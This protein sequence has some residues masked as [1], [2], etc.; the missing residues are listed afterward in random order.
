MST[1]KQL[2]FMSGEVSPEFQFNSQEVSYATGLKKLLNGFVRKEGGVSNRPGFMQM[3]DNPLDNASDVKVNGATGD[4]YDFPVKAQGLGPN[5]TSYTFWNQIDK[6][7]DI[8]EIGKFDPLNPDKVQYR[9]NFS[10][11][12]DIAPLDIAISNGLGPPSH[13]AEVIFAPIESLRIV[14]VEDSI[15]LFPYVWYKVTA[16]FNVNY[17]INISFNLKTKTWR[18]FGIQVEERALTATL[19]GSSN[20]QAP[21]LP[22]SYLTTMERADGYEYIIGSISTQ[23]VDIATWNPNPGSPPSPSKAP[24]YPHAQM[25]NLIK[26][27]V[28]DPVGYEVLKGGEVIR[29]YRSTWG[30]DKE[31]KFY[32]LAAIAT[33]DTNT[34]DFSWQDYG[35]ADPSITPPV[36]K[37]CVIQMF[38]TGFLM[39]ESS[40]SQS[41][42]QATVGA[43]H[44]QRLHAYCESVPED[45]G[46]EGVSTMVARDAFDTFL[47]SKMNTPKQFTQPLVFSPTQAFSYNITD[48]K[49]VK[50]VAML[51]MERL[52]IFTTEGVHVLRGAVGGGVTPTEINPVQISSVGCHELVEPKMVGNK[53]YYLSSDCTRIMAI[54]WSEEGQCKIFEASIFSSHLLEGEDFI[55]ME[56][57]SNKENSLLLLTTMGRLIHVTFN[58]ETLSGGFSVF[59]LKDGY[60]EN[61]VAL[62]TKN[63]HAQD[64]K[65]FEGLSF[66]KDCLGAYVIRNGIR[67]FEM[68]TLR[69]DVN[70]QMM[71]YMDSAVSFGSF[72]TFYSGAKELSKATFPLRVNGSGPK[73][74]ID[75][76][77]Y[78]HR[79][80]RYINIGNSS[81][82]D[83]SAGQVLP[84]Y[85][86]FS[87]AMDVPEETRLDFYYTDAK[88][89]VRT[90][91]GA[92]ES[93]TPETDGTLFTYRYN[94][95]FETDVPTSLRDVENLNISVEEKNYRWTN[96]SFAYNK[97]TQDVLR[98]IY[99]RRPSHV[100]LGESLP[101]VVYADRW[102]V[103]SPLNPDY[104]GKLVYISYDVVTD[105]YSI[106]FNG[107]F[108]AFGFI[109]FPYESRIQ[110]L[111]I[112]TSDNRTLRTG[113]VIVNS[114]GM[115][116][117]RTMGGFVGIPDTETKDMAPILSKYEDPYDFVQMPKPFSGYD[118]Y[119]IP[120]EY[121]QG[122]V[123]FKHVDPTPFTLLAVYP[124]GSA[125][126]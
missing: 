35:E 94:V 121:N 56:A 70:T 45:S 31:K 77:F 76:T 8:L 125:S 2:S 59:E 57:L 30:G 25:H 15:V 103:S 3:F 33:Y 24:Y 9:Y 91:R 23:D 1:G 79:F 50:K 120:S 19:S 96:H 16:T 29:V 10:D 101:V 13:T 64:A 83:Y 99:T 4:V 14:A 71:V 52:V 46:E 72:N 22:V 115:A 39:D 87:F 12:A 73:V 69:E 123:E 38:Q 7:W 116:L 62:K 55:R 67:S 124:K 110:T 74:S 117:N 95:V 92:I 53:G 89:N 51:S 60:I 27:K 26:Q 84:V 65:A 113:K 104:E 63:L 86:D 20:G 119:S 18:T 98:E 82:T 107:D 88:G 68:L 40:W 11:P 61:I 109:G 118:D 58:F 114:V 105:T 48:I 32:K 112:E 41:L 102:L 81:V 44:Q 126:N 5:I 80:V 78:N 49:N 21:Y 90:L 6:R 66:M 47:A 43:F 122:I 17:P 93:F 111:P 37:D 36:E 28:S 97:V 100:P 106:D 54:I 108:F 75:N 85:A 34:L 42:G